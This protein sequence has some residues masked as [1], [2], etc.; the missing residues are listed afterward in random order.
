MGLSFQTCCRRH[1]AFSK[2]LFFFPSSFDLEGFTVTVVLEAAQQEH[3]F[4]TRLN[5]KWPRLSVSVNPSIVSL[6]VTLRS[7][8]SGRNLWLTRT[9]ETRKKRKAKSENAVDGSKLG[10]AKRGGKYGT[11]AEFS[12][13][14]LWMQVRWSTAS[15]LESRWET[16]QKRLAPLDLRH[17]SWSPSRTALDK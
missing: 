5:Q 9:P 13:I 8:F 1:Q 11:T 10:V 12:R 2:L 7:L 16:C 14:D 15:L 3:W 4:R 17:L 6:A